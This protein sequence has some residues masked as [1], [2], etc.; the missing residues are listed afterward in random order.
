MPYVLPYVAGCTYPLAELHI[1]D[2]C[3]DFCTHAPIVQETLDPIDVAQGQTEYDIGTAPQT[4]P[5]LILG[6]TYRGRPLSILKADDINLAQTRQH[7]QEPRGILAGPRSVFEL[8]YTPAEDAAGAIVLRVSTKPT[9]RATNVADVLFNDYA[10]EIGQGAIARLMMIPG[11]EFSAP[12]L[13]GAYHENY[14]RARTE[15]RIRAEQ[16]FGRSSSRVQPRAFG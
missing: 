10:Y 11:H 4:E 9:R 8:D 12:A 15:A 7:M 1:R 5:A 3:I 14:L 16:S 13:A 2:I 6:A